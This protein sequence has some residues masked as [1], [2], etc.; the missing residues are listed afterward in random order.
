MNS[1]AWRNSVP[2]DTITGDGFRALFELLYGAYGPQR[3]WPGDGPVHVLVGAILTQNTAWTNVERALGALS[4]A[5]DLDSR[6]IAALPPAELARLIRPAGY[7]NV[8]ARRLRHLLDWWHAGGGYADLRQLPTRQLRDSLLGVHGVGLE[9]AHVI[10]LYVFDRPVF[11]VDAYARR[12]F[13]RIGLTEAAES[14]LALAARVAA[15]L[16]HVAADLNEFHALLVAHGK[17]R[18]RKSPRCPGCAVGRD[19]AWAA[20]AAV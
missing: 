14:D 16:D 8:K 3:W 5:T 12:C 11:V 19:C 1:P 17:A 18:C 7:F 20:A 13:G 9:T 4:T 10:L 6:R 15:A 2:G